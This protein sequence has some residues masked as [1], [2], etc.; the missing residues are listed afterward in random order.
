MGAGLSRWGPDVLPGEEAPDPAAAW[1]RIE[2]AVR[3][4]AP[5]R[6]GRRAS[7]G[8]N[9]VYDPNGY[10]TTYVEPPRELRADDVLPRRSTAR[11]S[12]WPTRAAEPRPRRGRPRDGR[13]PGAGGGRAVVFTGSAP[14]PATEATIRQETW[15]DERRRA[16]G[17]DARRGVP[18]Q[19]VR[20]GRAARL[21]ARA[22][23]AR[24]CPRAIAEELGLEVVTTSLRLT[25][26]LDRGDRDPHQGGGRRGAA[27][28]P[29]STSSAATSA[30]PRR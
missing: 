20:V 19:L 24:S 5:E 9:D 10:T 16:G 28:A 18:A 15:R 22:R 3:A 7:A 25:G 1:D 17:R 14:T 4:A 2:E 11:P 8:P 12:P 27:T 29:T 6:R 30:P 23:P 26:D 21:G 13:R